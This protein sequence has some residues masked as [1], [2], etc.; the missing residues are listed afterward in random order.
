MKKSNVPGL[1]DDYGHAP[2]L[3]EDLKQDGSEFWGISDG[4]H[5]VSR[6]QGELTDSGNYDGEDDNRLNVKREQPTVKEV[7][8]FRDIE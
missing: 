5:G 4:D 7:F 6:A 8:P 1:R 2:L 3:D